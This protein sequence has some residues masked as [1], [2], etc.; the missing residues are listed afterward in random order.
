MWSEK[1]E[2]LLRIF[3]NFRAVMSGR[4]ATNSE[5]IKHD[6]SDVKCW[7]QSSDI[8]LTTMDAVWFG[9][10]C[11]CFSLLLLFSAL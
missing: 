6:E 5:A 4:V 11:T 2:N 8:F 1:Y 7:K 9:G 3:S 10:L